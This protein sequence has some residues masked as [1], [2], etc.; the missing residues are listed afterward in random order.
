MTLLSLQPKILIVD[1][2]ASNIEVMAEILRNDYQ[3]FVATNGLDA[4]ETAASEQPEAILLDVVMPGMDGYQVCKHLKA[5]QQTENIP[6]I[7][8]TSNSNPE[9]VIMGV[10]VGAFYYITKPIDANILLAITKTAVTD[11][12]YPYKMQSGKQSLFG[13]P[14]MEEGVFKIRTLEHAL[15]LACVLA[16][17]CPNPKKNY[18]GLE[19]LIVNAIEHGSLGITYEEKSALKLTNQWEREV[20]HRQVLPAYKDK[21]VTVHL[22]RTSDAIH[23]RITDQGNGFDWASYLELNP[24]RAFD[25][26]GRGVLMAKTIGFDAI[27]YNEAGNEVLASAFYHKT[28]R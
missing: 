28:K 16:E 26:N 18:I 23:F 9:H 12:K 15:A 6:V 11:A 2:V 24:T 14:F 17:I 20:Q 3:I 4:L 7:F 8:V 1:D 13:L 10:E 22:Q 5:D 19:E 25:P 27:A 21:Y